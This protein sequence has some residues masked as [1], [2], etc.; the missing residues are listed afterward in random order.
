RKDDIFDKK[1]HISDLININVSFKLGRFNLIL[2]FI[3]Q[4]QSEKRELNTIGI[5]TIKEYNNKSSLFLTK[6]TIKRILMN[7]VNSETFV[8]K[9]KSPVA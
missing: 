2:Y 3:L 5:F 9:L 1:I 8:I 6:K 7:F 4:Y